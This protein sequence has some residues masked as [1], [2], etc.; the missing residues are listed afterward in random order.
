M[1][2]HMVSATPAPSAELTLLSHPTEAAVLQVL[3]GRLMADLI[4]TSVNTM[5]L[6]INPCQILAELYSTA[7]LERYLGSEP[8]LPPHIFLTAARMYR[9]V[10]QG[11]C[12][13]V[14]ISGESGAGK[15]QSFKRVIKFVSAATG[16]ARRTPVAL[17]GHRSVEQQLVST[18]QALASLGNAST[19]HNLDSSRFG[20]FEAT[21]LE[22]SAPSMPRICHVCVCVHACVCVWGWAQD[23][24]Q[25][26]HG[27][28]THGSRTDH[29]RI[30]VGSH[31][32]IN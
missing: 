30:T 20:K 2:D 8:D 9:G 17:G 29:G 14:V 18:V 6:A 10:L 15:T 23:E 16:G 24:L 27:R 5:R 31:G 26:D 11:H 7:T 21:E 4:Y 12:Q 19:M 28:I 1:A 3:K 25:S 13:S 32:F 22:L